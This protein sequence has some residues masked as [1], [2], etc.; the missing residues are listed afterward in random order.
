MTDTVFILDRN[1]NV[2]DYLSNN[3]VSPD[4]PF[5]DDIYIQELSNGVETYEFSTLSNARTSEALELGNYI[6]F[7]YDNKYKMFQIMDLEDDHKDGKQIINCYC[8]MAGLELLTDYCEPFFIEGNVELFFNTVLQDTNWS[9]GGY[10]S[11]LATNI[12]Q[13]KVDKYTNVYKV[14]QENISTYGNIEIEYRVEFDGNRLLGYFID[15][16]ENGYRGSKVYK[17]FEYGENVSGITRKR[18]LNDFASAMIGQGKDKLTFKDI[19][20]KKSNGD[21]ADKPKGQDFVVDLEA[22]DKFNKHGKYIKG[23]FDDSEITNPQDLLL[24]SWE[25]LQEVKEP[26]FDY[27]VDLALTSV[28]YEDIKIGDTN[29]VIDNDYNPPIFLEARIGKL[30]ISFTDPNKNKCTLSNYKEVASKIREPKDGENG[31]TPEI[32]P[33]GNWWVGGFDTGK[34]AQGGQ[35]LPGKDGEPAKYVRVAGE[36]V[37]KYANGFAGTPTPS[38][39]T[40]ASSV[41]GVTNPSRVWSYKTPS[42][43]NYVNMSST[44]ANIVIMHNDVIWGGNKSITVRCSVGDK[45]DEITLVKVSDGVNGTDGLNGA[46]GINGKDGVSLIYKGEFA[47]HPS[48]PQDGWYYRNTTDKKC[49]VYQKAWYQMTIDG[50]DGLNGN[51]GKDGLSI[52]YKGIMANPPSNPQKNWTYKDSDNGIVYIYTG[53]AW[54]V[55]TYDG[56]NGQDGADGQN[57]L[58]IFVTYNDSVTQPAIPTGNG[59]TNGWHTNSTVSS[60]WISQK[61]AS[62]ATTGTWGTPIKIKGES[63]IQGDSGY[64]IVLSNEN[65]AFPCQFNGN[66]P[67]AI[68]TKT[69]VIALKGTKEITPTIGT[70]PTIPGLTLTK[71]GATITVVANVGTGLADYGSF[72]I[73]ITVDGIGFTKT[74]TWSKSK[75]GANGTNGTNGSNGISP[76]NAT[77]SGQS[78]MKYLD[79]TTAPTPATIAIKCK[80]MKGATEVTGACSYQWQAYYSDKWNNIGTGSS[81]NIAYNSSYFLNLDILQIR[82]NVTYGNETI[83]LEHTISKVYDNKYITQQEIFNKLTENGNDFLYTD[84]NTGKIY[85]NITYAKAGQLVADL[86]KGGILTLGGTGDNTISDYGV[87]RILDFEGVNE[88]ARIDGGEAWFQSL[89]AT[90]MNVEKLSVNNIEASGITQQVTSTISISI[91]SSTGNDESEFIDEAIFAT[92]QGALDACPRNL[93]GR[94]VN[95]T[96]ETDTQEDIYWE[97]YYSGRIRIYWNGKTIYG[98]MRGYMNSNVMQFFGGTLSDSSSKTG[99]IMPNKGYNHAGMSASVSLAGCGNCFMQGIDIYSATNLADGCKEDAALCCGDGGYIYIRDVTP[100]NCT[101]GFRANANAVVYSDSTGGKASKYGF[102]ALSGGQV[103]LSN[104]KHTG[105]SSGNTYESSGGEVKY[106]NATFEGTSTSGSNTSKPNPTTYKATYTSNYGDTY[107]SSK[108]NSWKKDNTVRQGDYGYGDCNGAWFFSTKFAEL[109]G[110]TITKVTIKI[111]RTTGGTSSSVTHTLKAHKNS[112]RPGGMPSYIDGYSQTFGLAVGSSTTV[113][114]TNSTVLNAIKNGECKGFG[115]QSAYDK[116]HYSVCKGSATVT[117]YYQ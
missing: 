69:K 44:D 111:S 35:G 28:E 2:I 21:P 100:I 105:G 55:L 116:S 96:L 45:Y 114:I 109:K 23:L 103:R 75:A 63:G 15:V 12:Q 6:V 14:I 101:Y 51:N 85:I 62:S 59:T 97:C 65:H 90:E 74:F 72:D 40:I 106:H 7:K 26:K 46:D 54:E 71:S 110:R 68:T 93:G 16:Y 34:P 87:L 73:P 41:I 36:Q 49:Y 13:V 57:G 31:K 53:I 108:Y 99:K 33:N 113:T 117:I 81:M 27:E 32:G 58:S 60:V 86:I 102:T 18:N 43:S 25:K 61:V 107:R 95:I 92:L 22:N 70:L 88:L 1:K 4:A 10:S 104:G 39:I 77:L 112:S 42:M 89:S 98:Y 48:S 66:I 30:E 11:S 52:E 94:T 64:T 50:K 37:F 91:N 76:L 83:T 56:D 8:E 24:K 67:N 47:A 20:W 9:L 78:L 82:V 3:G 80:A 19:E 17:R 29:Y 5:F 38:V 115:L 84:P 79:K